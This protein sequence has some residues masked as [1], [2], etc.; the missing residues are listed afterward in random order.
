[1]AEGLYVGRRARV[2]AKCRFMFSGANR[3]KVLTEYDKPRTAEAEEKQRE[4]GATSSTVD[5]FVEKHETAAQGFRCS[6]H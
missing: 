4:K 6:A 5:I 3:D 1:M 2:S